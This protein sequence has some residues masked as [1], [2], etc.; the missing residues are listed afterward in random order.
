MWQDTTKGDGGTD[1]RV[2]F[3]VTANSELQVARS[4]TL[5]LEVLGSIL[6]KKMVSS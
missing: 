4:D 3:F 2:Q 5:D 6:K 1:Q